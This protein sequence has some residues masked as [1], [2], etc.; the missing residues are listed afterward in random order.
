MILQKL[1]VICISVFCCYSEYMYFSHNRNRQSTQSMIFY[2]GITFAKYLLYSLFYNNFLY[3]ILFE[4]I[5]LFLSR[6]LFRIEWLYSIIHSLLI[7][8]CFFVISYARYPILWV[9]MQDRFND[10]IFENNGQ[11]ANLYIFVL[12]ALMFFTACQIMRKE[13][14]L[15]FIPILS[16]IGL[17]GIF[18]AECQN[19]GSILTEMSV[20]VFLAMNLI[21]FGVYERYVRMSENL[22]KISL[23]DQK[24]Q[25]DYEH[26]KLLQSNYNSSRKLIHDIKHHL[27]VIQGMTNADDIHSY[28]TA[29]S[30]QQIFDSRRKLTGNRIIDIVINQKSEECQ[31]KNITFKFEH[32]QTDFSFMAETDICCVFANLLDNAVES[33]EKSAEKYVDCKLYKNNQLY[34]IEI[35]NSCDNRPT[36]EKTHLITSKKDKDRHGIGMMSVKD[37]VKKYHGDLHFEYIEENHIF[38]TVAMFQKR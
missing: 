14:F 31:K 33:A 34:F 21:S 25:L 30:K 13:K 4:L 17:S 28:V 29:L 11:T 15:L 12:S 8:S 35:S 23:A 20:F 32:N 27:T 1:A 5:T 22:R 16:I 26:Y 37:T 2:S 18:Y 6:N 24:K 38:T 3:F 9:I 36:A 10:I 19:F 7:M